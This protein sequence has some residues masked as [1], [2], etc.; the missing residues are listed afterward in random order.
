MCW[1]RRDLDYVRSKLQEDFTATR[2]RGRVPRPIR[3]GAWAAIAVLTTLVDLPGLSIPAIVLFE[4][5]VAPRLARR[6]PR[7]LGPLREWK[8]PPGMDSPEALPTSLAGR[9][10][11]S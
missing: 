3:F 9:D 2:E 8:P 4:A 1:E 11:T 7:G 6:P 5:F 10:L